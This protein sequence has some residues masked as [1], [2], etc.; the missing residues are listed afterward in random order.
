MSKPFLDVSLLGDHVDTRDKDE[1]RFDCPYC[2]DE[3]K[4]L[5]VNVRKGVYHCF[6]C[7]VSGRTNL[8]SREIEK[9][10]LISS[11]TKLEARARTELL[12]LP[13]A[14][15]DLITP[16]ALKYLVKRGIKESDVEKWRIYCAS[17]NS[18]YFGR[19]IIPYRPY[20]GYCRYFVARA[21][22]SLPW[23]KYLNPS[24]G[25]DILFFS[26]AYDPD[27]PLQLW[28]LDELVLVEGPF[29]CIKAGRYGPAAA[30][31]GKTLRPEQAHLIVSSFSKVY[32]LL[33]N[34]GTKTKI[35]SLELKD[36]L[37]VHVEVEI[38]TCPLKDPGEMEYADFQ[39]LFGS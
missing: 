9:F 1:L 20:Q 10:H 31:L 13:H 8:K 30:L 33:D 3:G 29:D 32:V 26:P 39:G 38:L 23:P 5:Y 15:K 18:K 35:N 7:G 22:T 17:P 25:R 16:T 27:D 28:G 36:L 37:S 34:E 11:E 19:L 14:H 4:H 2:E 21:Y 12:K 6:R 24:G